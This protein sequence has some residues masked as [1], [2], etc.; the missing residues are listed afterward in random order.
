[1]LINPIHQNHL[2]RVE[3][4][5]MS[6]KLK[7]IFIFASDFRGSTNPIHYQSRPCREPLLKNV[8][9]QKL[10]C[11]YFV[12]IW[13]ATMSTSFPF[14]SN[15][16]KT[17]HFIRSGRLKSWLQEAD[18][19]QVTLGIT[20][21]KKK[22]QSCSVKKMM[23]SFLSDTLTLVIVTLL[24]II[25]LTGISIMPLLPWLLINFSVFLITIPSGS[26]TFIL[27]IY[28]YLHPIS[29]LYVSVL[30]CMTLWFIAVLD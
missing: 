17:K 30:F 9:A 21:S 18:Q 14:H 28:K 29:H 11:C 16:A 20:K 12:R 4:K 5:M 6:C 13:N 22:N 19:H 2:Y 23:Q 1:M 8:H 24:L 3:V 7:I 15:L 26:I 27:Q 25:Q 10:W